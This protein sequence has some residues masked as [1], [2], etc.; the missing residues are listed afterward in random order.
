MLWLLASAAGAILLVAGL[1]PDPQK[2]GSSV[3]P[4]IT[5]ESG[6]SV[7]VSVLNGCGAPK[8]AARMTRKARALG[9]DVIHEGNADSFGFLQSIVIDRSGRTE[10]AR[11]VASLLGIPHW[12]QQISDD[13]YR[14]EDVSIII[15]KD[16]ERLGLLD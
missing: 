13:A 1:W 7:R 15:G 5:P 16:F 4:P 8:V 14:L 9:L 2:E 12:I 6:I 10:V 3:A 11:R